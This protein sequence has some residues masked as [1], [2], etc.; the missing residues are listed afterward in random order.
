MT[1]VRGW[2]AIAV[3]TD[4]AARLVDVE[5]QEWMTLVD[6]ARRLDPILRKGDW[7]AYRHPLRESADPMQGEYVLIRWKAPTVAVSHDQPLRCMDL[8]RIIECVL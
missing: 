6:E 7:H 4:E 2:S 8:A 1:E 3:L 5:M